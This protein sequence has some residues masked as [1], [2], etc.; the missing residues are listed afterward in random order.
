MVYMTNQIPSNWL[1]PKNDFMF[2]LI[3]GSD[4]PL[5]REILLAFV[6]DVLEVP[7]GQSLVKLEIVNPTLNKENLIFNCLVDDK[8]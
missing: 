4:D 8:N 1:L 7:V 5:S 2:K 6:N 3:F